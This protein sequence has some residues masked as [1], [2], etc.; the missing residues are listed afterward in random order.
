MTRRTVSTCPGAVAATTSNP[1]PVSRTIVPRASSTQ[2]SRVISPRSSAGAPQILAGKRAVLVTVRGG[3]YGPGTP[4]AGWDHATPW[5]RR[6]LADVWQVELEVVETEFTLVGVD[7]GMDQFKDLAA[8]LRT[9]AEA[10]AR[11]HGRALHV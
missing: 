2:S 11:D 6:I 4:R 5:M 3:A 7:P 8:E 9:R 1:L 10:L